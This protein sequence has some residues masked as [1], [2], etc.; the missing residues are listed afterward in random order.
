MN[1]ITPIF[2]SFD[3]TI[4]ILSSSLTSSKLFLFAADEKCF[5]TTIIIIMT[6]NFSL[7]LGICEDYLMSKN[8]PPRNF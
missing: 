7:A 3:K 2:I 6:S 5:K 8:I 4:I 1:S